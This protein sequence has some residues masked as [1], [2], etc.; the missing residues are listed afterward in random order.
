MNANL[1]LYQSP[2]GRWTGLSSLMV[3]M[4]TLSGC[5]LFDDV[6]IVN[7]STTLEKTFDINEP[8]ASNGRDYESVVT[9]ALQDNLDVQPYLDKIK[10]IAITSVS[11]QITDYE[12]AS[13]VVSTGTVAFGE[14]SGNTPASGQTYAVEENLSQANGDDPR[15]LNLNAAQVEELT[16]WLR[17][18]RQAK[19]YLS[20]RLSATPARFKVTV[21]IEMNVEAN[22]LQ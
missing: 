1:E 20:G 17:E 12:G 9:A 4:V 3:I 6:G 21:F 14:A 16:T 5:D 7:F 18:Q 10:S 19:V 22:A 8:V 11:Y 2:R 13:N 15:P